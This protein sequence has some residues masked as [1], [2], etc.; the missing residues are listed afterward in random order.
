VGDV[1]GV[2]EIIRPLDEKVAQTRNRLR[3][4][5]LIPASIAVLVAVAVFAFYCIQRVQQTRKL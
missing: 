5:F 2:L 4:L 1:R 3:W